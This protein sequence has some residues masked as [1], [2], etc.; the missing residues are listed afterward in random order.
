MQKKNNKI[1]GGQEEEEETAQVIWI[2]L[3]V[4][5]L[6]YNTLTLEKDF[7]VDV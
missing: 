6:D 5:L 2:P 7:Q 4:C 3:C 1:K